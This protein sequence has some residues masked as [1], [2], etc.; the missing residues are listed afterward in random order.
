MSPLP[1]GLRPMLAVTTATLPADP[2]AWAAK[3]KWDGYRTL[4]LRDDQ[5]MRLHS[6]RGTDMAAWFGELGGLHHALGG[7][8]VVLDGEVV[9]LGQ[10]DYVLCADEKTSSRRA[11]AAIRPSPPPG[12]GRCGWN[13]NISAA[14]RC[15]PGRLGRPSGAGGRPLRAHHRD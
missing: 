10:D 5:R 8:E 4:C 9:A 6:R 13:T 2:A 1:E 15:L 7:H 3:V 12:R 14:E 11:A